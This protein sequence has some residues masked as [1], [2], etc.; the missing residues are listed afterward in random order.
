MLLILDQ[1][2]HWIP[3]RYNKRTS[4]WF[5]VNIHTQKE[6]SDRDKVFQSKSN[7]AFFVT[8]LCI[9]LRS[10]NLSFTMANEWN[11]PQETSET[12]MKTP[13]VSSD[14]AEKECV[15]RSHINTPQAAFPLLTHKE[16]VSGPFLVLSIPVRAH[17]K[18]MMT[19]LA[20]MTLWPIE[21]RDNST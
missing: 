7:P 10:I 9:G 15:L 13:Y 2:I 18:A 19:A 14:F 5:N 6:N 20:V 3:L 16:S 8:V 17:L 1:D 11:R 12:K 4:F 21:A